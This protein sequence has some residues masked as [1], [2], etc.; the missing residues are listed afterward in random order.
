MRNAEFTEL[1]YWSV[2]SRG[3]PNGEVTDKHPFVLSAGSLAALAERRPWSFASPLIVLGASVLFADGFMIWI[4]F[5]YE[6]FQSSD[7]VGSQEFSHAHDDLF[8]VG[9]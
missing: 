9:L 6:Q 4:Q 8:Q 5:C 2:S 7:C 1:S 3:K